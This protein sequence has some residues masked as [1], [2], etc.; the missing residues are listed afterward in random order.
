MNKRIKRE[1]IKRDAATGLFIASDRHWL[2]DEIDGFH[3]FTIVPP[4]I[5]PARRRNLASVVGAA[6]YQRL[7]DMGGLLAAW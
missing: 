1:V 5:D 4:G 6:A 3:K 2:I 7:S